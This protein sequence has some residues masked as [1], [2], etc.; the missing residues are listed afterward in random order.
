MLG[1][2]LLLQGLVAGVVELTG[3]LDVDHLERQHATHLGDLGDHRDVAGEDDVDLGDAAGLGRLEE[4][5]QQ[6]GSHLLDGLVAGAVRLPGPGEL[7]R[8]APEAEVALG[9]PAEG[10]DDRLLAVLDQ[11][12]DEAAGL[13]QDGGRVGAGHAAVGGDHE[14]RHA[15]GVG[16]LLSDGMLEAGVGPQRGHRLAQGVIV[17]RGLLR[18]AARLPDPGRGDELHRPEHLLEGLG[19]SNA[20]LVDALVS[21][22]VSPS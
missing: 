15:L 8:R 20:L 22:H 4:V 12:L 11:L 17:G 13:A 9:A 5:V 7:D 14:D 2:Q 3:P 6:G 1:H 18:V 16:A 10:E 19:R 21:C